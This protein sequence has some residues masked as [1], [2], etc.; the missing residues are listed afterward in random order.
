M[1]TNKR[2][3]RLLIFFAVVAS[4]G[5]FYTLFFVINV[6]FYGSHPFLLV[7]PSSLTTLIAVVFSYFAWQEWR[8]IN[9]PPD[10]PEDSKIEPELQL[11][12]VVAHGL[13]NAEG[14][15]AAG[16]LL[17]IYQETQQ[18]VISLEEVCQWMEKNTRRNPILDQHIF[19]GIRW[20]AQ[21]QYIQLTGQGESRHFH[22]QR[23]VTLVERW[24]GAQVVYLGHPKEGETE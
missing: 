23:L 8:G 22:I 4:I 9:A 24:D 1:E 13:G 12:M 6:A 7:F 20:L 14:E 10:P 5:I 21:Q 2:E 11:A 16:T 17:A 19:V 18:L 15:A 3:Y